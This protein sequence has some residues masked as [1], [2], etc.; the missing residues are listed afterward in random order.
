MPNSSN[1]HDQAS[2]ANYVQ[3]KAST[4]KTYEV[5]YRRCLR[6]AIEKRQVNCDEPIQITAMDLVDDWIENSKVY[7]P[8]TS[9]TQRSALLWAFIDMKLNGWQEAHDL[10]SVIHKKYVT[11]TSRTPREPHDLLQRSR[12]PGRMIP[13]ADLNTLLNR[14]ATRGEW[15]ARAQWFLLAG[16]ASGARPAEWPDAQ[17]IDPEKTV[18]RIF[19]AKVK[20]RNAWHK[21]PP[22]TFTLQDLDD[23][24]TQLMDTQFHKR[25]D[26]NTSWDNVDFQRRMSTLDLTPEERDE[27]LKA[28][29]R[30]GIIL[31]RDVLIEPQYRLH[32]RLHMESVQIVLDFERKRLAGKEPEALTNEALFTDGYFNPVRHCIWRACKKVFPNGELYSLYDTRS[33]F[34]ANRKAQLGLFGASR[35][36]GHQGITTSRDHYAPASK[37]WARYKPKPGQQNQNEHAEKDAALD[38]TLQTSQSSGPNPTAFST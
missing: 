32:V 29:Y 16:I 12:E 25:T 26:V 18:L 20:V 13:E 30:N 9:L 28:Q 11:H 14:L 37:A 19:N 10:L 21:V 3:L 31:F 4:I 7:S 15:G 34:G 23:E 35:D 8:R 6:K 33:T 24:V 38:S 5:V 22:L 36:L 17:W 1:P 2:P 27:L